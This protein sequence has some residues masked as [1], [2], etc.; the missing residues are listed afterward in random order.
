MGR[1]AGAGTHTRPAILSV[2]RRRP[3][4]VELVA[5]PAPDPQKEYAKQVQGTTVETGDALVDKVMRSHLAA[6]AKD[7]DLP[8]G[9]TWLALCGWMPRCLPI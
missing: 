2:L 9:M 1:A 3:P 8:A 6:H 7:E 5:P 4:R